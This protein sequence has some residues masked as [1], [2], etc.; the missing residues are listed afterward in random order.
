MT[1]ELLPPAATP[2][3][4]AFAD[5]SVRVGEV[6][7]DLAAL[8][9]PAACPV[10]LL[11]WLA[12]ALSIDRWDSN[13]SEE[14]RRAAVAR[15]IADQRIKGTRAAVE[16]VLASFDT[17]AELVEWFEA[18]PVLDPHTFEI[19]IPAIDAD[20]VTDGDRMSAATMRA[21][22]RE[23]SRAKPLRSHLEL[24]QT[25]GLAGPPAPVGAAEAVLFR[26]ID[27]DTTT[28]V[29]LPWH[30]LIQ[31]ENGEPLTDD[32]GEFIDGSLA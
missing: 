23:V 24:V 1:G 6:P 16:Q 7:I 30:D 27:L 10:D 25:L 9:D 3:E 5:A 11:P 15:A 18:E 26:R 14:D 22:V 28:G 19:R 12:W 29:D 31:D 20:G 32:A 13:W 2:L 8:W 17:L 21:I 4:Q